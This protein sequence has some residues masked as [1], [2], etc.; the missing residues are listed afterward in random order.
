MNGCPFTSKI[1]FSLHPSLLWF[2]FVLVTVRI[3]NNTCSKIGCFLLF[4]LCRYHNFCSLESSKKTKEVLFYLHFATDLLPRLELQ[5]FVQHFKLAALV[6]STIA[7]R[8][9]SK[10]ESAIGCLGIFKQKYLDSEQSPMIPP[11]IYPTNSIKLNFI[12][13]MDFN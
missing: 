8:Q 5:H 9:Q 3:F 12:L 13:N 10:N 2:I 6:L 4:G 11:L 7:A 1:I